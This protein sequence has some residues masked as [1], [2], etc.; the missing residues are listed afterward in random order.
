MQMCGN[1]NQS[2]YPV[3]ISRRE[4]YSEVL[5]PTYLITKKYDKYNSYLLSMW[6][7]TKES[8]RIL[9]Q[10]ILLGIINVERGVDL[11]DL[12][13]RIMYIKFSHN[14]SPFNDLIFKAMTSN[15]PERFQLETYNSKIYGIVSG[16]E[17]LECDI[18]EKYCTMYREMSRF[19]VQDEI[20]RIKKEKFVLQIKKKQW[21]YKNKLK[22]TASVNYELS[23]QK[24][25]GQSVSGLR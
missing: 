23:P 7:N 13:N 4:E 1:Y 8:I 11:T 14:A 9:I 2:K 5:N 3:L 15:G 20:N 22:I 16:T 21:V 25:M 12:N 24:F 6:N 18:A 17:F 19:D 10:G